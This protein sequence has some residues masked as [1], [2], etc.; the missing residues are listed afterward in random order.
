MIIEVDPGMARVSGHEV[1]RWHRSPMQRV[2]DNDALDPILTALGD[3]RDRRRALAR[4]C[5][6]EAPEVALL[7][8]LECSRRVL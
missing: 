6:W 4:S 7:A 3:Q 8:M 2:P 5:A 1:L